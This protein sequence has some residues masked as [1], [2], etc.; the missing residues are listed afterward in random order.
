MTGK[1]L[2]LCKCKLGQFIVVKQELF[3]DCDNG[4]LF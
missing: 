3:P 4:S 2:Y 1:D